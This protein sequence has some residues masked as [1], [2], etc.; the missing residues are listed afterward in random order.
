M[1][2]FFYKMSKAMIYNIHNKKEIKNRTFKAYLVFY[3]E[4]LS[5]QSS[6]VAVPLQNSDM[7]LSDIL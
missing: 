4:L 2:F 7:V 5:Q 6:F 3:Y 1:I